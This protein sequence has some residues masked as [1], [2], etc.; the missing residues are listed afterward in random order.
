VPVA[1]GAVAGG[2]LLSVI[3]PT[4]DRAVMLQ[5]A[6]ASL[7]V[8][9]HSTLEVIVV[10]DESSDG[11]DLVVAR[12]AEQDSRLRYV[13]NDR[14]AG[15]GEARNRGISVARGDYLAFCDDDDR[16]EPE[17]AATALAYLAAHQQVGV[18]SGWHAVVHPSTG[19]RVVYRGA[20]G[21]DHRA[22]L[23]RNFIAIPFGVIRRAAYPEG[24]AFDPLLPPAEDW[25]LWIRCSQ[26]RPVRTVPVV[27][28]QYLQ[29]SS[30]RV[31]AQPGG[32]RRVLDKHGSEM[33]AR[34]RQF[35]EAN[36][37]LA[38]EKRDR[39]HEQDRER[40]KLL[41]LLRRTRPSV[42]A[43]VISQYLAHHVGLRRRDPALASRLLLRTIRRIDGDI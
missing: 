21:Y 26:L 24:I 43:I 33:T 9:T 22:L 8:Q 4:K 16:W 1:S 40:D 32:M 19:S 7:M 34:C 3:V 27:L 14:S 28:Y 18:V 29:H 17:T 10:D 23:W 15:P 42:S 31:A 41:H 12:L 20:L 35:H 38:A 6:I 13:R 39:G 2:P 36:I 30:P 25:D 5:G 37:L 11:T